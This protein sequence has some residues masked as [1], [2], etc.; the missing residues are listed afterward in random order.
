MAPA[1]VNANPV[2]VDHD[3]MYLYA[4][5]QA[6][7]KS[8]VGHIRVLEKCC[9]LASAG[10][11][12]SLGGRVLHVMRHFAQSPKM[13]RFC[14]GNSIP[15]V[16]QTW[17]ATIKALVCMTQRRVVVANARMDGLVRAA[18]GQCA[19]KVKM[20]SAGVRVEC[21]LMQVAH[22]S[23]SVKKDGKVVHVRSQSAQSAANTSVSA[24]ALSADS[25]TFVMAL[26]H[27]NAKMDGKATP[28]TFLSALLM[29]TT[30]FAVAKVNV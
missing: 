20:V 28:V 8:A 4:Q 29:M 9:Q 11:N 12:V 17:S 26:A 27:V 19:Q 15:S 25:R 1:A 7:A 5:K 10:V 16:P 22:A 30:R 6:M 23:A 3:A 18:Q 2:L 13:A 14:Q 24:V 21:P